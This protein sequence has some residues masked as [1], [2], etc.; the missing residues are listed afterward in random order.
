MHPAIRS[1]PAGL[2]GLSAS[3]VIVLNESAQIDHGT[4]QTVLTVTIVRGIVHHAPRYHV[5][6]TSGHNPYQLEFHVVQQLSYVKQVI[7][8]HDPLQTS[9]TAERRSL[10]AAATE[11]ERLGS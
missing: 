1:V 5:G 4:C 10:F 8:N 9:C 11:E 3:V 2:R 6:H 7:M